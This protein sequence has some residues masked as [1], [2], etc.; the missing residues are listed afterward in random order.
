M[1]G[2]GKRSRKYLDGVHADVR[3]L[4]ELALSYSTIDMAVIDGFRTAEQQKEMF[5]AGKSELDG[6]N[7]ISDHQIGKA[8]DVIP[9]VKGM[10]IWDVE[11]PVVAAAWLEVYRSYLRAAMKLGLVLEFGLGYDIA[12]GRDYPHISIVG[13]TN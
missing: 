1:Y 6:I 5:D 3:A 9:Y 2:F 13:N 12:G 8:H 11:D 7:G 4:A 10:D